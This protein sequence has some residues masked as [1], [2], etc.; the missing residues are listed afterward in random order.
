MRKATRR[1]RKRRKR[2]RRLK[3]RRKKTRSEARQPVLAR[4]SG[5]H[6]SPTST[7]VAVLSPLFR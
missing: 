7:P 6:R 4:R 2:K 5:W 3:K 1:K